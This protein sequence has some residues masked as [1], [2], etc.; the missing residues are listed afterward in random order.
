MAIAASL[1]TGAVSARLTS[2]DTGESLLLEVLSESGH[3]REFTSDWQDAGCIQADPQP[4]EYHDTK[5]AKLTIRFHLDAYDKVGQGGTV[6]P[7][8]ATLRRLGKRVP[9]KVRA[10]KVVYTHGAF[11]FA[12]AVL[13]S[14][15]L[16]VYRLN[17]GGLAL[18][19]RE[20]TMTLKEIPR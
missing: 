10:H 8:I 17:P 20:G 18:I 7:E 9:G 5:G 6:E 12:P 14:V 3:E 2:M 16:P 1:P 15:H 19:V 13:E 11:R 4:L